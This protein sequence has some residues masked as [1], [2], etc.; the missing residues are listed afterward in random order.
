MRNSE[1]KVKVEFD[2]GY[3]KRYT[4]A[5]L[6]A[7]ARQAKGNRNSGIRNTGV[8][9]NINTSVSAKRRAEGRA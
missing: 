4:E 7:Y 8:I 9:C 1:I 2:E 3:E 5:V 6:K